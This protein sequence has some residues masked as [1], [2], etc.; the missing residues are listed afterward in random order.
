M[1]QKTAEIEVS[2]G[3]PF[4]GYWVGMC[5]TTLTLFL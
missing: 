2:S 4:R 1:R 3:P 5:S